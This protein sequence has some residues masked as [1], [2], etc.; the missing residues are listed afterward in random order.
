MTVANEV[1]IVINSQDRSG[2]GLKSA[3]A[4]ADRLGQSTRRIGDIAAGIVG[5]QVFDSMARAAG[6]AFKSTVAAASNL[7]E[8]INAVN[9]TF[10]N[11]ADG[12]HALGEESAES[13]GLSQAAFNQAAVSFANFAKEVAGPGGDVAGIIDDITTRSADF[14]SV[15][16][17]DVNQA[18]EIFRS[19][20]A[21]ESEPLRR[22]GIDVSAAA[23][24]T[25]AY[26][27]GIAEAGAELTEAQKV[28]ARYG[29]I[30]QQTA[31][32][33]DDFK[34]TQDDV[35]NATRTAQA[36]L[37]DAQAEIGQNLLPA[38][39][40]AA[41][42]GSEL[43]SVFTSMPGPA[44]AVVG[45]VGGLAAGFVLLAPKAMAAKAAFEALTAN[46]P[47][48]ASGIG[49]VGK[50]A[51][52]AVGAL[53]GLMIAKEIGDAFGESEE[54]I[55]RWFETL[56]AGAEDDP[57]AEIKILKK[58]IRE[59]D[60][61]V[62]D[63][64]KFDLGPIGTFYNTWDQEVLDAADKQDVLRERLRELEHQQE[65]E[66]KQARKNAE[67]KREQA[68]ASDSFAGQQERLNKKLEEAKTA[69]D[70]ATAAVDEH[71]SA[72]R[73]ATDP[74]HALRSAEEEFA[75]AQKEV[76]RLEKEGKTDTKEYEAA[77]WNLVGAGRELDASQIDAGRSVR[78]MRDALEVAFR[79]GRISKAQYD[80]QTEALDRLEGQ[81]R[82]TEGRYD[83]DL[84]LE[85]ERH[86]KEEIDNTREK[87][88]RLARNEYI[89][90]ISARSS[91]V[92][93]VESQLNHAARS[94]TAWIST[95][96]SGSSRALSPFMAHG[97]ISGAQHAQG[98]G[99][100]GNDTIVGENGPEMVELPFGSRVIP[101]GQTASRVAEAG[102]GGEPTRLV[103][104][105]NSGGARLDDLLLEVLRKSIRV[106]G[107]DVQLVLGK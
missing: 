14:A 97:G 91:G 6:R 62:G 31:G 65:L 82:K 43:L 69:L 70:E 8:S 72:I 44:Q 54:D 105:I 51:G 21:G 11:A 84:V 101:S 12:V 107:G 25:F 89:A 55:R 15:M 16:N 92:P 80:R 88:L 71:I 26:A 106:R 47:R 83:V 75:A 52:L 77:V 87:A 57:A 23:T 100:R 104:E 4:G 94:R 59:L 53:A 9:V 66:A 27:N 40:G 17:M 22:Y 67:A 36:Q 37:E 48:L 95:R 86:A 32:M 39:A 35:A 2:P 42:M 102:G 46:S 7:G 24:E 74:I 98:G 49:K 90:S 93:F 28:Q 78:E 13:I 34:N 68:E 76:N 33:A 60:K 64:N 99:P 45:V 56:V 29:L 18:M 63:T 85:G 81:A 79:Q 73:D 41:R 1:D 96:F 19:G 61:V 30:M 20:L 10:G 3:A 103:L 38:L 50:A 5:S 58:E